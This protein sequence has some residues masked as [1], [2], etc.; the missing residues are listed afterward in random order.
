MYAT[1][2]SIDT[3]AS[4][5]RSG[6]P[7]PSQRKATCGIRSTPLK[8]G[9]ALVGEHFHAARG[10][11]VLVGKLLLQALRL[12]VIPLV[13]RFEHTTVDEQGHKARLV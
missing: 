13:D 8:A 3:N 12:L 1:L 7:L 10:E 4:L 11:A 2:L 5:V 6:Y 9:V